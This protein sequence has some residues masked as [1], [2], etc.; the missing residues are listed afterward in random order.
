MVAPLSTIVN[1]QRELTAWTDMDAILYYG[2]QGDR[3]LIRQLEF[4]FVTPLSLKEESKEGSDVDEEEED[5]MLPKRTKKGKSTR[6]SN[7]KERKRPTKEGYKIEVVIT[8]PETCMLSDSPNNNKRELSKIYWE[9]VIV[10]EAHK[11]KNHDSKISSALRSEFSYRQCVLLTGTPLQNNTDELWTLLN[12]VDR[13]VFASREEF[14]VKY[15]SLKS[16]NQLESLLDTVKPYL[17]RR[18][19]E[20]VE[21]TVPPKEEVGVFCFDSFFFFQQFHFL[22]SDCYLFYIYFLFRLFLVWSS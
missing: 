6:K 15:G 2:S 8:T 4:R 22:S 3:D 16:T 7:K 5:S 12:F 10:D 9:M 18:E 19:K 11:L 20:H 17:L 14:T 13:R 21:K 1:W